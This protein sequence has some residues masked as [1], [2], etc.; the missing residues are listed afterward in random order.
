M[1]S[2]RSAP[3]VGPELGALWMFVPLMSLGAASFV[4]PLYYAVRRGRRHCYAWAAAFVLGLVASVAVYSQNRLS[5]VALIMTEWVAGLIATGALCLHPDRDD[6]VE[7]ARAERKQRR[8]ARALVDKDPKLAIEAGIGRPDLP[9]VHR[10]GGLVDINRVPADFL[11][12]LPGIDAPLAERIRDT[13]DEV[14]GFSSLADLVQTL[15]LGP[16]RFADIEDQLL[17]IRL[18]L[19]PDDPDGLTG[20]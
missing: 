17:F 15:D 3:R 7:A 5:G 1:A 12:T 11:Q 6:P 13:R 10:D 4:P 18:Y 19:P 20:K 14:G 2:R 16:A 9:G 8:K